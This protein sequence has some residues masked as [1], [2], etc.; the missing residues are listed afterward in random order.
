MSWLNQQSVPSQ[1]LLP[2]LYVWISMRANALDPR[3]HKAD[4]SSSTPRVLEKG[5]HLP[6]VE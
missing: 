6:N 4:I 1:A 2:T 5:V 3:A